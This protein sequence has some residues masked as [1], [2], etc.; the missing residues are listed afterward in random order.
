MATTCALD[1]TNGS[2][3]V[4]I[5]ALPPDGQAIHLSAGT[6]TAV[7]GTMPRQKVP[8][9]GYCRDS[10]EIG[11]FCVTGKGEWSLVVWP[12]GG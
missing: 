2:T 4:V 10:E 1:L 9:A 5:T 11:V 6:W 3:Q 8:P 12:A 7:S